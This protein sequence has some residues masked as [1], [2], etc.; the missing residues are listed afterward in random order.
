MSILAN[1]PLTQ[2]KIQIAKVLYFF[3]T[4]FTG[5]KRRIIERNG[6]TYEVDIQEGL[7]LSLFL[8]GNFQKHVSEN[9]FI[10]LPK[11]ATIIDVG[12][13]FGL[14]SLNYAKTYSEGQ[15]YAFEPTH[16]ALEKLK[17]NL[18]LNPEFSK[19]IRVTNS[20]ISSEINETP[21]IKAYSSWKVDGSMDD[22]KH[23][24]HGGTAKSTDG[25]GSIT[26]DAFCKKNNINKIDFVKIDTDGHELEILKGAKGA[27]ENFKPIIIFEIGIYVMVE[28][29]IDFSSYSDYFSSINFRMFNSINGREIKL[30]NYKNHIPQKGTID[31]LAVHKDKMGITTLG[32]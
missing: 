16:Y 7:D 2:I 8:F 24:T 26:L 10:I 12:A 21:D 13:N 11:T 9:R 20:F 4:L 25:V 17:R 6:I 31:I 29:G 23:V 18:E 3:V 19:R 5:K 14:M 27:I 15:I 1:L 32:N 28:R 30:S 22:N